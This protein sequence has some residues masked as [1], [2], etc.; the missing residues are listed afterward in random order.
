MSH[1]FRPTYSK[2]DPKTGKKIT[3][4]LRKW[5]GSYED[6][7]GIERRVPLCEDKESANAMLSEIVRRVERVRAGLI[8]VVAE[9][10]SRGIDENLCEYRQSLE[11]KARDEKHITSTIRAIQRVCEHCHFRI[12]SDIQNANHKIEAFLVERRTEGK[13]HRTINADLI[14]IRSFCRWLV[15]RRRLAADPTVGLEQIGRASCGERV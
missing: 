1:L 15:S 14:A 5:Y 8:D 9:E 11:A 10:M 2:T 13:S 4:T 12:L 6:A 7:D 3:R